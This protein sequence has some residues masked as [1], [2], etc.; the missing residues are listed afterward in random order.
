MK[1]DHIIKTKSGHLVVEQRDG[2]RVLEDGL[3]VQ[4]LLKWSCARGDCKMVKR[5]KGFA[6]VGAKE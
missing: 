5:D 1:K 4:I 3:D 2:G 6:R